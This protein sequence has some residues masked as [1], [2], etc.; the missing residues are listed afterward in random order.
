MQVCP[1]CSKHRREDEADA[2]HPRRETAVALA[3]HRYIITLDN[4]MADS[5]WDAL[6]N[7]ISKSSLQHSITCPQSTPLDIEM[8]DQL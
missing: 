5:K 2:S 8:E 6:H 7:R 3:R 4:N 1:V